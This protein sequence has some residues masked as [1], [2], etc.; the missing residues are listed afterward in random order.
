MKRYLLDTNTTHLLNEHPA[1]LVLFE[2]AR[3]GFRG[4]FSP[5]LQ[6]A[7]RTKT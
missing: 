6:L 3:A 4:F 1:R 2:I 7:I 5:L